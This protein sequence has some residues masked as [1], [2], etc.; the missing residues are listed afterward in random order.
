M[1]SKITLKQIILALLIG[2]IFIFLG[3]KEGE[4]Q[5]RMERMEK[6][7]KSMEVTKVI[8]PE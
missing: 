6:E 1:D 8:L 2:F 5:K 4:K 7:I 3:T